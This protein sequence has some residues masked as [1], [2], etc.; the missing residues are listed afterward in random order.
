MKETGASESTVYRA[1]AKYEKECHVHD[2][3]CSGRLP[4][5]SKADMQI[6][7][8]LIEEHSTRA[9]ASQ[10]ITNASR[11]NVSH[12]MVDKALKEAG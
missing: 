7:A 9:Y 4:N 2:L 8:D 5:L 1:V 6:L 10:E 3:P 11:L 12:P